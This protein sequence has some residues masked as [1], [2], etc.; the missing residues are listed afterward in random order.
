M[1]HVESAGLTMG[2]VIEVDFSLAG[3][4]LRRLSVK[5]PWPSATCSTDFGAEAIEFSEQILG[6][7]MIPLTDQ[8]SLKELTSLSDE[9]LQ[10]RINAYYGPGLII[11]QQQPL[12]LLLAA[13]R[14][15]RQTTFME[16]Q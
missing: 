10:G 6:R 7:T 15:L 1:E 14:D 13:I 8:T 11:D 9:E 12:W 16:Q 5:A 3:S 2:N 4:T